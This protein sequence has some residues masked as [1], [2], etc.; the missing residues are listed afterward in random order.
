MSNGPD[1]P[2]E[3]ILVDACGENYSQQYSMLPNDTSLGDET[4]VCTLLYDSDNG[5]E[6][7]AP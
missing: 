6:H 1:N 4:I 2:L 3:V 5:I 7:I